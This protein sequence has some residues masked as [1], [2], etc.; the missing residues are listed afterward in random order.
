MCADFLK[1]HSSYAGVGTPSLLLLLLVELAS[2]PLL[3]EVGSVDC[4][5]ALCLFGNTKMVL[6]LRLC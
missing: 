5:L 1:L 2:I 6:M 4:L 3:S